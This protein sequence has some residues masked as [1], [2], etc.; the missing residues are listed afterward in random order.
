MT[1]GLVAAVQFAGLPSVKLT[2]TSTTGSPNPIPNNTL[3]DVYRNHADGT[4]HR[5]LTEQGPRLIGGGWAWLD[6]HCPF[7]QA[8]TYDITAAGFTATSNPVFVPSKRTWLVHPSQ[9]DLSVL[10]DMVTKV[11]ARAT[12]SRASK[13]VPFD[14][15]PFYISGGSREPVS[16]SLILFTTDT[17]PLVELFA[18]DQVILVNTP[19][20][21]G[22]D[23]GWMWVQPG[24]VSYGNPAD[25]VR[26]PARLVT[27]PFDE[28]ADPDMDL[29]PV[30]SYDD[31]AAAWATYTAMDAAY[32]SYLDLVTD[33]RL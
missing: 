25:G 26:V 20:T 15:K 10:V 5:V 28:S 13:F 21:P 33:T 17:G 2:G 3:I 30:W 18:D 7:N 32:G 23:I 8:V 4:R 19:G 11:D 31:A 24:A 27:V 6:V 14:G 29:D 12:G 16:G 9:A 1:L 22:W